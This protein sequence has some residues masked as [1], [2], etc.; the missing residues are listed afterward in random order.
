MPQAV[1]FVKGRRS[2]KAMH[3]MPFGAAL[4]SDVGVEF[5]L[6]APAAKRVQLLIDAVRHDARRNAD[7]WCRLSVPS[8]G[9]GTRYQWIIDGEETVPD[10]A[11]RS[12]PE[13]PMA[14]R[15]HWPADSSPVQSGRR[16]VAGGGR[17]E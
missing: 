4:Q 17:A 12:N 8:A 1:R 3:H 15:S 10:P 5:R 2:M 13:G 6:W 14:G 16:R 9:N 7:G 11:S